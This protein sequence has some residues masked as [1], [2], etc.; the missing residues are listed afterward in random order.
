MWKFMKAKKFYKFLVKAIL[1]NKEY[2]KEIPVSYLYA[3]FV[4]KLFEQSCKQ[5]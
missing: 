4:L 5:S 3:G 2:I 1:T